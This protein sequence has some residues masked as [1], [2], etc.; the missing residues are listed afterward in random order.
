VRIE[1]LC[2]FDE[3]Q[4]DG[5]HAVAK[6][7]GP[8]AVCENVA[9][10]RVA[11]AARDFRAYHA[12]AAICGFA[13]IFLRD[14][15][16]ETGPAGAGFEFGAGVEECVVAA[17]AAED[18]LLVIVG[19]FVGVRRFGSGMTRDRESVWRKLLFPI[20]FG[21]DD[22]IDSDGADAFAVVRELNDGDGF[23]KIGGFDRGGNRLVAFGETPRK[24][25]TQ[26]NRTCKKRTA[27]EKRAGFVGFG[28][29]EHG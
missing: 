18:S 24:K 5:V 1:E 25:N 20:G 13:N 28:L 2:G 12:E 11:E 19:I 3:A 9:E 15:F 8:R 17:D 16:P 10:M 14:G 21:F 27:A 23:R 22:A 7:G 4:S 6:T 26:T 29:V